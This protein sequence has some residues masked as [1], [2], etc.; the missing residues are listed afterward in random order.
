MWEIDKIKD[1]LKENLKVD[2]YYHTLGVVKTAIE[3]AEVFGEDKKKAEIAA[4]CH[5]V[6]KN[7]DLE[8]LRK[9]I[10]DENIILSIDEENT[11]EIWH[12]IVAPILSK[13]IFGIEDEEVLSAMRWHTTGKENMSN[14]DKI[15]YL[16]DLIEPGRNFDG[17]EE[18]RTIS[19]ESL[20]LAM[21]KAL[22]HTT[23][24]L[25]SKDCAVDINTI[26]ARNYLLYNKNKL[27]N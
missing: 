26:K 10:D 5:D 18:I 23:M 21:I 22:T 24:Y 14:L 15:V 8:S 25:L 7:M 20:D 16:S 17:I 12:S 9:I 2:R 11:K 27:D 1:Y 19:N 3:L 13:N 6:A 4:L